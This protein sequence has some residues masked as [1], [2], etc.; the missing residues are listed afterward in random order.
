MNPRERVLAAMELQQTDRTP[1][2]FWAE[3]ATL[4]QL[5]SYTGST[6]TETLLRQMGVDIRHTTAGMPPERWVQGAYQ[7]A[8][9]ERYRYEPTPWGPARSA[10]P[11]A[12]S[13]ARSFSDLEQF[14]WPSV[15]EL[16][17]SDLSAQCEAWSDY[18]IVYGFADIWQRPGLVRGW[19]GMFLDMVDRPEWT[20]Y[21]C[22]TFTRFFK[23]EYT[24]AAEISHGRIDLFLVL[25]DLGGQHGPLISRTMFREFVAP[26]LKEMAD[27]IHSLGAKVLYH[28][29]GN[30]RAFVPD[31]VDLGVDVL[32]PIQPTGPE[33]EPESLASEWGGRICFHGGIDVQHVLPHGTPEEV[34]AQVRRYCE[35]LGSRGGYILAPAHL[36]QPDIPPENILAV[37]AD[38]P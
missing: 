32:D 3:D 37:Y 21:L 35:V 34:R 30:I 25:S 13:T 26:Y 9:G 29:C 17:F 14:R 2:D 8:W 6:D 20:H 19:E 31:L 11:G 10:L 18:A 16:D 22:R 36:F 27:T 5:L 24:R 15:D 1:R 28:S 12:L 33:M 23:E 4:S 7:N 38:A